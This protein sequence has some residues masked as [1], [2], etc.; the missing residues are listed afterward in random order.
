MGTMKLVFVS[1]GLSHHQIAISREW[2][3]LCEYHFIATESVLSEERKA[4]GYE[5]MNENDFVV[6]TRKWGGT[7]KAIELIND[8]DVVIFGS[9]PFDLV[10]ERVAQNKMT[11]RYSERLLKNHELIRR[12]WSPYVWKQYSTCTRY[13][14]KNYYLLCSGAFVKGDYQKYGAFSDGKCFKW[15][16][17]PSIEIEDDTPG[18]EFYDRG[19]TLIWCGRFI[20]WKHPELAIETADYLRNKGYDFSLNMI[21][22]GELYDQMQQLINKFNLADKVTLSGAVKWNDVQ[23]RMK[24]NRI[25][26]FTSDQNEGWGAVLNE[27]MGNGCV[28]IADARIG[29]VPYLIEDGKSGF[30]YHSK[31]ELFRLTEQAIKMNTVDIQM[32]AFSTVNN[33]WT[34]HYAARAFLELVERINKNEKSINNDLNIPCSL[35]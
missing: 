13:K 14:N 35:A 33:Y 9:A 12:I 23:P 31:E 34:P 2:C 24:R 28:A 4:L 27:A 19:N 7:Q 15:G 17:F 8:A 16:Y 21:G 1:N 25:L 26:L 6:E 3:K 10:K 11:F 20:D 22:A 30:I 32:K 5:M 29:S 18:E